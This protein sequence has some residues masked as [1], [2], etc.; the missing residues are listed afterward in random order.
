MEQVSEQDLIRVAELLGI[1]VSKA[2]QTLPK[3]EF[4][5]TEFR[6]VRVLGRCSLCVTETIQHVKLGRYSSTLWQKVSE[7]PTEEEILAALH[8]GKLEVYV[9]MVRACWNCQAVLMTWEKESLVNLVLA[10]YT[11]ISSKGELWER[12][13]EYRRLCYGK[14]T[15]ESSNRAIDYGADIDP[16]ISSDC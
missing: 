9:A 15:N 4:V 11:S 8:E 1:S 16:E 7:D 6:I 13:Q 3:E 14:K 5:P 2:K 10:H 12:V